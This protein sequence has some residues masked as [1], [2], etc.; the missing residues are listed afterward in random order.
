MFGGDAPRI[1]MLGRLGRRKGTHDLLRAFSIVAKRDVSSRLVCA[2][3]G[4]IE[5]AEALA[6]D[7]GIEPRVEFP[8]WISAEQAREQ[9]QRATIFV[10]PSYAEGLPMAILEAMSYGL[11]VITTPVGGVPAVV[12]HGQTGLLVNAG[13]VESLASAISDLL[14]DASARARLGR[15]AR[16][17]VSREYS[18]EAVLRRLRRIYAQYGVDIDRSDPEG[19][20][21]LD[22]EAV[23]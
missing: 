4:D 23:R 6:R 17:I 3:D 5:G 15:A 22:E 21:Y 8:G 12:S 9:L 10:L 7:L 20:N 19:T 2:G 18:L 13:A 14:S 11:P 1:L 16:A